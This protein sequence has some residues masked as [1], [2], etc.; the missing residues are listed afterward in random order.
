MFNAVTRLQTTNCQVIK[1]FILW[2]L[3][4][5]ISQTQHVLPKWLITGKHCRGPFT[6]SHH[7][8]W[9]R[10]MS[11]LLVPTNTPPL[12]ICCLFCKNLVQL[13]GGLDWQPREALDTKCKKKLDADS[14]SRKHRTRWA[15]HDWQQSHGWLIS[16][17]SEK[18]TWQHKS[19]A[20]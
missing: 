8:S 13:T 15:T 9:W 17:P 16:K 19:I 6:S 10:C 7:L 20:S 2:V 12:V 5:T 18:N 3:V 4:L 1:L 14:T 11:S